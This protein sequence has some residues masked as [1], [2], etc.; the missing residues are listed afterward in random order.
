LLRPVEWIEGVGGEKG[1][2][3]QVERRGWMEC[4]SAEGESWMSER[5]VFDV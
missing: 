4:W 2:K 5:A 3:E 1:S